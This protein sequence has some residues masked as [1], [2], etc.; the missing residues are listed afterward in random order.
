MYENEAQDRR[1]DTIAMANAVSIGF[2]G[3]SAYR[4]WLAS[5][6]GPAKNDDAALRQ[7]G[8]IMRL[9]SLFGSQPSPALRGAIRVKKP[10]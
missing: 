4:S 2:G 8:T 9:Q 5:Q 1:A 10:D 6:D 7:Q 3:D